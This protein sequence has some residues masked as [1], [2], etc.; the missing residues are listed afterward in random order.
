MMSISDLHSDHAP[1]PARLRPFAE[2]VG[3]AA[4]QAMRDTS[5]HWPSKAIVVLEERGRLDAYVISRRAAVALLRTEKR[6]AAAEEVQRTTDRLPILGWPDE[7]D[8]LL[9]LWGTAPGGGAPS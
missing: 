3:R 2:K 7:T 4:F 9:L 8:E 5:G 1:I 6:H